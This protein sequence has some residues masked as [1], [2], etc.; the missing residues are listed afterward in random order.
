MTLP[1]LQS[2]LAMLSKYPALW[3]TNSFI[4]VAI[5]C[6]AMA[7]TQDDPLSPLQYEVLPAP[8]MMSFGRRSRNY[9]VRHSQGS[10]LRLIHPM[11][12]SQTKY[13]LC[14]C[15]SARRPFV[16]IPFHVGN[17]H[18]RTWVIS[19]QADG[20][21]LKHDHRHEDGTEDEITQYGGDT[22][23]PGSRSRQ[24]FPADAHTAS[25]VPTATDHIWSLEINAGRT[26]LYSL[27]NQIT[28]RRVRLEFNLTEPIETLPPAPWG[29]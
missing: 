14:T 15:E 24:D 23:S 13:S 4:S 22:T 7:C 27:R 16:R 1:R 26:F 10:L 9:A 8:H 11:N 2:T 25:L 18:S 5:L 21:R 6:L 17:D 3:H 19:R 12:C 29:A 28:G 20:L